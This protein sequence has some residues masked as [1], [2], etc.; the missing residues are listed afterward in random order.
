M[1]SF[2][3]HIF[4]AFLALIFAFGGVFLLN[5]G[6]FFASFF[7][8]VPVDMTQDFSLLVRYSEESGDRT[9]KDLFWDKDYLLTNDR[10]DED[11]AVFF[12]DRFHVRLQPESRF[13][14]R[15]D[16]REKKW[17]LRLDSGKLWM[18]SRFSS[19]SLILTSHDIS[20]SS[21]PFSGSVFAFSASPDQ[22]SLISFAGTASI[23]SPSG[24]RFSVPASRAAT[25][26]NRDPVGTFSFEDLRPVDVSSNPWF[27]QNMKLDEQTR[28]LLVQEYL[29]GISSRGVLFSSLDTWLYELRSG[30]SDF[31]SRLIIDQ[32]KRFLH[33]AEFLMDGLDDGLYFLRISDRSSANARFDLF[34]QAVR[35]FTQQTG[36]GDLIHDLLRQRFLAAEVLL[37]QDSTFYE[38]KR[39]VREFFLDFS[40]GSDAFLHDFTLVNRTN[41]FDAQ[42]AISFD[43][44]AAQNLV[45]SY[46]TQV[47]RVTL[48]AN[49]ILEEYDTLGHVLLQEPSFFKDIFFSGLRLL[50]DRLLQEKRDDIVF[51]MHELLTKRLRAFLFTD[52]V[53]VE[54]ARKTAIYL[55]FPGRFDQD[56]FFDYLESEYSGSALYGDLQK[57]RFTHYQKSS[58]HHFRLSQ[59]LVSQYTS[60][61]F[62]N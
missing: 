21:E 56:D 31:S 61:E 53:S 19:S 36:R 8:D 34:R 9:T 7:S 59:Y 1:N 51:D 46:F 45:R 2:T 16:S 47:A 52:K 62:N 60:W 24:G 22:V 26:E 13:V 33:R 50:S 15:Y 55:S 32:D 49:L 40:F 42:N 20:S 57:D 18:D 5:R 10:T 4:V 58:R 29:D 44:F 12:P 14:I 17:I 48:P 43:R 28:A 25:F 35:D 39:V 54:D 37:P 11:L 41:L 6:P 27:Q 23:V 3:R 38:I 30:T